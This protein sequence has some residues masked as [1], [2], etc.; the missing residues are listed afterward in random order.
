MARATVKAIDDL[1]A[2]ISPP[3]R[4]EAQDMPEILSKIETKDKFNWRDREYWM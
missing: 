3:G 1:A 4:V 2:G